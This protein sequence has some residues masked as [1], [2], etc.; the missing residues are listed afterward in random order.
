[1]DGEVRAVN[2]GLEVGFEGRVDLAQL[3]PDDPFEEGVRFDLQGAIFAAG[4]A[5]AILHVAEQSV[6]R[7]DKLW[8]Q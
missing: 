3:L 5:E 8:S 4:C 7:L 2:G 1:M 6:R